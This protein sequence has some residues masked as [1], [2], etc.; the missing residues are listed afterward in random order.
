MFLFIIV[1]PTI[2]SNINFNI[3]QNKNFSF[4]IDISNEWKNCL[5]PNMHIGISKSFNCTTNGDQLIQ[6]N[7]YKLNNSIEIELN[8]ST[9]TYDT[10]YTFVIIIETC[11][12]SGKC[13]RTNTTK[14]FTTGI[15]CL[16]SY[17]FL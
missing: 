6:N 8:E 15:K 7:T 12:I 16:N 9:F 14:S 3:T 17:N 13:I 5:S 4:K 2:N 11:N 1:I 10:K